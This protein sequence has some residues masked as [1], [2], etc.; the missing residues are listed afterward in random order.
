MKANAHSKNRGSMSS[1]AE[2]DEWA[3]RGARS[4][5]SAAGCGARCCAACGEANGRRPFFPPQRFGTRV[6]FV[7]AA[8]LLLMISA[9]ATW[10]LAPVLPGGERVSREWLSGGR[11]GTGLRLQQRLLVHQQ[12]LRWK[13]RGVR[14]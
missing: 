2:A 8:G 4:G 5:G 11:R 14:E 13:L 3:A 10:Y 9:P 6:C 7:S 1:G 12:R